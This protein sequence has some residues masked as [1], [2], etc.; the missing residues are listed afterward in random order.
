MHS[1]DNVSR[2][3]D[4]DDDDDEE[5]QSEGDCFSISVCWFYQYAEEEMV[6]N[7]HSKQRKEKK[8]RHRCYISGSTKT[9]AFET[10][11]LQL[12]VGAVTHEKSRN[13]T[14]WNCC[15]RSHRHGLLH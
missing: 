6:L 15:W 5:L 4:D 8:R 13:G 2:Y 3:D 12:L 14:G 1:Q 11:R 7:E 10:N 9:P